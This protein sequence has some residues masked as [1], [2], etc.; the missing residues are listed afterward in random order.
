MGLHPEDCKHDA[1]SFSELKGFV[2]LLWVAEV[3]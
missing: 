2:L 1:Q 3:Q